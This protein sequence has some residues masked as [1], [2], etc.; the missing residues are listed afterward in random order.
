MQKVIVKF[1]E[2]RTVF[3]SGI[4][5]GDTNTDL[6][7]ED[8]TH[9][10]TLSA[11]P[12]YAPLSQEVWVQGTSAAN[13]KIVTF[14]RLGTLLARWFPSPLPDFTQLAPT[15]EAALTAFAPLKLAWKIDRDGAAG[16]V[17]AVAVLE[18]DPGTGETWLVAALQGA[19]LDRHRHTP[20]GDYGEMIVTL[21][22]E[23]TDAD[24]DGDAT[25][26]GA[27]SVAFHAGAT[28]HQPAAPVFWLGLFHQPRGTTVG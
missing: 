22:G 26:L 18:S 7:V 6:I 24:D 28:T 15:V 19:T 5:V 3:S 8:G 2:T 10:F 9:L 27:N 16:K 23:L 11:Q 4:P 1:L 14:V 20:G 13:P 25:K 17:R 21:A 12:D